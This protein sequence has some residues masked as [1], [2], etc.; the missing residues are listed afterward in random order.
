MANKKEIYYLQINNCVF[1]FASALWQ[2]NAH[3]EILMHQVY[4]PEGWVH[5]KIEVQLH[6][7]ARIMCIK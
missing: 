4:K 1:T 6:Y 3:P 7:F 5:F 2:N